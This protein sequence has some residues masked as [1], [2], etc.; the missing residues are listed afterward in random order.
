MNNLTYN[1]ITLA[2]LWVVVLG[3]GVYVTFSQQ[4]A[5][6]ERLEK[7]YEAMEMERAEIESLL[8]EESSTEEMVDDVLTRWEARYKEIPEEL[9]SPSVIGYLNSLTRSGFEHFDVSLQGT[10]RLENYNT[11]RF[12]VEGQGYFD[13]LYRTIWHL[14]NNRQLYA[15]NNLRLEHVDVLEEDSDLGTERMEVMVSF[16]FRVD[17]YFGGSAGMS[18]PPDVS[19]A[20]HELDAPDLPSGPAAGDLPPVPSFVLPSQQTAVNPF[21][22]IVMEDLPPNTHNLINVESEELVSIVG[23]RAVFQ[24]EDGFRSVSEGEDVYLGRIL[25]VDSREGRI[26]ARL[27][28]GGIVDDI[29]LELDVG[30]R[31]RRPSPEGHRTPINN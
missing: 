7:A 10:E 25:E 1:I 14:E 30:E 22:P 21:F 4:P 2:A 29:E 20:S 28:K 19:V 17:A 24:G 31:F 15:V 8:A 16:R 9:S 5:E 23:D 12:E 27:N 6:I 11:H 26:I 3:G 13:E 18:A